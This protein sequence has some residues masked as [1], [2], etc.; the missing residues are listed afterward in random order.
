M[1]AHAVTL[2]PPQ[3]KATVASTVLSG[4]AFDAR[5][6]RYRLQSLAPIGDACCSTSLQ[7]QLQVYHLAELF[8]RDTGVHALGS[9]KAVQRLR[10][11]ASKAKELLS[12]SQEARV[13]SVLPFAYAVYLQQAQQNDDQ[14]RKASVHN[15]FRMH[16]RAEDCSSLM[17]RS[18]YHRFQAIMTWTSLSLEQTLS[19]CAATC[20]TSAAPWHRA[21]CSVPRLCP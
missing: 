9:R 4:E 7:P 8:E 12:S 15:A 6:V 2:H 16:E 17:G 3:V 20:S 19:A 14:T 13:R 21:C 5:L 10:L 11:A 18:S 1:T